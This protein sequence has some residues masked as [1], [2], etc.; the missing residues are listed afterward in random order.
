M[1]IS[2]D[3]GSMQA[4]RVKPKWARC[5]EE[6]KMVGMDPEHHHHLFKKEGDVLL[7]GDGQD[8]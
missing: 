7:L 2:E 1:I 4:V 6:R 5:A 8:M 3:D